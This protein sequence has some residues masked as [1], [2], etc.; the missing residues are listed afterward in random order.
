MQDCV[1]Y[2]Q[3]YDLPAALFSSI[4]VSGCRAAFIFWKAPKA[5]CKRS[6]HPFPQLLQSFGP[7]L[8]NL[9]TVW[10][11]AHNFKGSRS[12]YIVQPKK[13][14]HSDIST[15]KR[16]ILIA[17]APIA[18]AANILTAEA[19]AQAKSMGDAFAQEVSHRIVTDFEKNEALYQAGRTGE[20]DLM[21]HVSTFAYI[22]GNIYM[23]YY[24][25]TKTS[26]EDPRF[27]VARLVYC[28]EAS[29]DNK[30]YLD[31]Q[32]VGDD[33]GGSQVEMVYDTILI[34]KDEDTLFLL[35][36]AKVNGNYYRLYR[37]YQ[38]ASGTL[39]EVGVNRFQVGDIVNDFSTTGIESALA[40]NEFGVKK[41][42][43]D[44]GIMQKITSR[45]E[46]GETYY[47]TGAY[48]GD[49]N[50][51]IKSRDL[52]TWE[53]VSQPDFPNL[54]KWENAT[55]VFQ[56]QC[57]Y[58]VRQQDEEK[59]GFL[60]SYNLRTG[61]WSEPVL[62]EDCQSRSDFIVY[63]HELFLFHAPINREHIGIVKIDTNDIA[64]SQVVLQAD[65]H[66][67]CFYPF[68]QYCSDGELGISYTVDRKHIRLARF[69][70]SKYLA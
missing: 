6:L 50:C 41:M 52:I 25:N 59:Y 69:L 16:P 28:P 24:A 56:D 38:I 40:E 4:L 54:S 32:S 15:E 3:D 20:I 9:P 34:P 61:K 60:T 49:F 45:Q 11:R 14:F 48:S 57:Y 36:A 12:V 43:S 10:G 7:T 17:G 44:I 68:I 64:K 21:A 19:S 18:S 27:H 22:G 53:Y 2:S 35:W 30:V 13:L 67:S 33:C 26:A 70:L 37:T 42:Y 5:M 31:I 23:T 65:M 55:Y 63:N 8:S 47:Y 51:I 46:N 39:S 66:G 1:K 58:F 62:I 29:P